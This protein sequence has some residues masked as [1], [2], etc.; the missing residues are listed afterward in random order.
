MDMQTLQI[1]S[2]TLAFVVVLSLLIYIVEKKNWWNEV[3]K[4][5]GVL[6]NVFA[7]ICILIGTAITLI[8]VVLTAFLFASGKD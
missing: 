8:F 6:W 2:V 3:G 1:I 7:A 4:T 5:F